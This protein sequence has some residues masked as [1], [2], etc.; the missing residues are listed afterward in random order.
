MC[1]YYK[2]CSADCMARNALW[3]LSPSRTFTEVAQTDTFKQEEWVRG[4]A[5]CSHVFWF[6]FNFLEFNVLGCFQGPHHDS[7]QEILV[8]SNPYSYLSVSQNGISVIFMCT[9]MVVNQ[10]GLFPQAAWALD[11]DT[12]FIPGAS[13]RILQNL[14]LYGPSLSLPLFLLFSLN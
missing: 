7:P 2:C 11:S 8:C 9:L 13:H 5:C 10:Q 1:W 6:N 14:G 12:R 3:E 4:A